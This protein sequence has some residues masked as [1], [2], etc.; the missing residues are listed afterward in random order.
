MNYFP[1]NTVSHYTT[2][3]ATPLSFLNGAYEIGMSDFQYVNSWNNIRN[4]EGF[5]VLEQLSNDIQFTATLKN[6]YYHTPKNLIDCI[7]GVLSLSTLADVILSI[8]NITQ[9]VKIDSGGDWAI[10]FSPTLT[11][12]LGLVERVHGPG[13]HY[14][15]YVVDIDRGFHAMYVYCSIIKNCIV[16]DITAQLLKVVPKQGK[17]GEVVSLSFNNI[18]FHEIECSSVNEVTMHITMDNGD[19]VP[20]ERGKCVATLA[21]RK[22]GFSF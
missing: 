14:G 15:E 4:G 20:F 8:D 22:K 17:H 6:G 16:G 5:M 21:Y 12:M 7:N 1:N 18:Q 2:K 19:N 3:L 9:K 11:H 10:T 13:E